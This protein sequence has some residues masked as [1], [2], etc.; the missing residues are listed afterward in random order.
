[1]NRV[2]GR[3]IFSIAR[4]L[5][6]GSMAEKK[7]QFGSMIEGKKEQYMEFDFLAVLNNSIKNS[8]SKKR[9]TFEGDM[10][11]PGCIEIANSTVNIK[12][13]RTEYEGLTLQMKITHCL[14]IYK[15]KSKY[16]GQTS[17]NTAAFHPVI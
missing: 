10:N 15:S 2:N 17:G 12:Q 13:R 16:Q 6:C 1:M 3:D 11:C 4:I 8:D 7:H 9:T 14:I 5:P